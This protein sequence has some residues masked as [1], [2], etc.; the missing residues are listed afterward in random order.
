MKNKK[1]LNF[2]FVLIAF[3]LGLTLYRQFDFENLRFEHTGLAVVYMVAFVTSI[4]FL[5]KEYRRR[6]EK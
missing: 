5:V 3:I 6:P 2:F 4:Y 1:S